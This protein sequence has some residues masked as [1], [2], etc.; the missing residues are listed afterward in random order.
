MSEEEVESDEQ[1]LLISLDDM[2][3]SRQEGIKRF[4]ET[5]GLDVSV[6]INPKFD[7]PTSIQEVTGNERDSIRNNAVY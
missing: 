2:L 7:R 5:Y 6:K 4:N 1:V 3:K